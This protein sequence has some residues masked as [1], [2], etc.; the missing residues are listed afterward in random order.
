MCF[1]DVNYQLKCQLIIDQLH[2]RTQCRDVYRPVAGRGCRWWAQCEDS[3]KSWSGWKR[4][5]TSTWQHV[6]PRVRSATSY[7]RVLRVYNQQTRSQ[8]FRVG[9]VTEAARVNFFPQKSWRPFLVVALKTWA[10]AEPMEHWWRESKPYT[11]QQRQ[12]FFVKKFTHSTIGGMAPCLPWLRPWQPV[13]NQW[14]WCRGV[15][16]CVCACT[17]CNAKVFAALA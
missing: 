8:D 1:L 7:W 9:G 3:C 13:R 12:F 14:P 2:K 16:I 17:V 4:D 10:L 6:R 15:G 5:R 11:S